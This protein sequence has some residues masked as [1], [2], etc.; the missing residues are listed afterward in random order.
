M[1]SLFHILIVV[2]G[3][4]IGLQAFS[5]VKIQNLMQQ[6]KGIIRTRTDLNC[7]RDTINLNML[8]AVVYIIVFVLFSICLVWFFMHGVPLIR[9]SLVLFLFGIITLPV[10]FAGKHF[11]KKI[12]SLEV[13]STDPA[14][15]ET[16]QRYLKQWK[17]PRFHLPA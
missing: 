6:T 8:L 16:F 9:V 12:R 2:I 5:M 15:A 7:V 13:Q 3:G 14:I 10:G 4:A 1:D 17:E 11:E